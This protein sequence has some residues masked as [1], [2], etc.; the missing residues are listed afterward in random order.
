MIT[1]EIPSSNVSSHMSILP[2]LEALDNST[3]P[4]KLAKVLCKLKIS[5]DQVGHI[6]K[7]YYYCH[8]LISAYIQH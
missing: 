4:S 7:L 8:V 1:D 3:S 6:L 2:T 5:I